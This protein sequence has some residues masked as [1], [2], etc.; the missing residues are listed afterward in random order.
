MTLRSRRSRVPPTPVD[1]FADIA[2]SCQLLQN[3]LARYG[4]GEHADILREAQLFDSP[5]E[6]E[7]M[8][9]RLASGDVWGS[10]G[11]IFD[12]EFPLSAGPRQSV[13]ED[14]RAFRAALRQL[15]VALI[16]LG[17]EKE[18]LEGAVEAIDRWRYPRP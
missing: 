18:K 16:A 10:A 9:A 3:L 5:T 14:R 1:L 17:I 6:R 7:E 8:L 2:A 11:S 4:F 15:A 13:V 12:I